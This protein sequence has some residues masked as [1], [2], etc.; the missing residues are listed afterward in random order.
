HHTR[1]LETRSARQRE[2][3][4]TV[5]PPPQVARFSESRLEPQIVVAVHRRHFDALEAALAD[6]VEGD[7]GARLA[8][9][10]DLAVEIGEARGRLTADADD[11][12][13][14]L[15][16]R[17]LGRAA[18]GGAGDEKPPAHFLCR[19][20]DPGARFAGVTAIAGHEVEIGR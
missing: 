7:G 4:Q 12:V 16:A 1:M 10:P 9:L 3:G 19:E 5:P 13:A 20:A 18:G 15:Q 2:P 14:F 8:L 6:D 17:L 11:D